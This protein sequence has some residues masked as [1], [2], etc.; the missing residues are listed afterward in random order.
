M[1]TCYTGVYD[2]EF[3]T[4][5]V[6]QQRAEEWVP[7]YRLGT[8]YMAAHDPA[9]ASSAFQKGLELEPGN[10]TMALQAEQ[11]AAQ[12]KYEEQCRAA[13]QGLH[14]RDLVLQLRAVRNLQPR[15]VHGSPDIRFF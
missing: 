11:S 6:L 1:P 13:Y 2:E 12:A 9:S 15:G 4:L 10:R 8:A 14:Q 7:L 5:K 3:A